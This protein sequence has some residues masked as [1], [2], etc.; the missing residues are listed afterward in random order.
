MRPIRRLLCPHRPRDIVSRSHGETTPG[1]QLIK[2]TYRAAGYKPVTASIESPHDECTSTYPTSSLGARHVFSRGKFNPLNI[3]WSLSDD[4]ARPETPHV[5]YIVI[6]LTILRGAACAERANPGNAIS[7]LRIYIHIYAWS[8]NEI[9]C[10]EF[11][12]ELSCHI[13]ETPCCACIC[14]RGGRIIAF[15]GFIRLYKSAYNPLR[16]YSYIPA[17]DWLPLL[18]LILIGRFGCTAD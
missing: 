4:T 12:F 8:A 3:L 13:N 5:R 11:S 2:G 15:D 6:N 14:R 7:H 9:W 17:V 18:R 16:Q 10:R 1:C